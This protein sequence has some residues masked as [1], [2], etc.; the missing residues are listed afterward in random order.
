MESCVRVR[1]CLRLCWRP[2]HAPVVLMRGI[3]LLG[4]Q[5]FVMAIT[6][7]TF[8]GNVMFRLAGL[9]KDENCECP[10]SG[11]LPGDAFTCESHCSYG[12]PDLNAYVWGSIEII[13]FAYCT[14]RV[15]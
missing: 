11:V 1:V 6:V 4:A 2:L 13:A 5:I 3:P 14:P 15:S 7:L 10:A 12:F 9:G 8:M